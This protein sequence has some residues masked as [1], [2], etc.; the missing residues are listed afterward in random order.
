MSVP[1]P[2]FVE[3]N[4]RVVSAS[5]AQISVFDR[6]LLY[7]DGLFETV[8]AYHGK[9]F[10]LDEH[11]ARLKVSA[12]FLGIVLPRK[13]WQRD[14]LAL[15][16]R[17][18]LQKTDA[19]VRITVTRGV[20]ALGLAPPTRTH[21]TIIIGTGPLDPAITTAQRRGVRVTFLPFARNG[22]LAEHKVLNYLP[23]VLGKVIAVR[24]RAFEGLFVNAEGEV[25]EGTTSNLFI[26]YRGQ[27]CT[28]PIAGILP[29][30]TR[31][32][33]IEAAV[34]DGV[35]VTER[36]VTTSDMLAADEAF[37]TSSLIEVV[38]ITGVD[39]QATGDG[40]VGPCTQRIQRLCRK[41]IDHALA[42]RVSR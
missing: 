16:A 9:P 42:R 39:A 8:R 2:T 3:L 13:A 11:L 24:H 29:G 7:G 30:L 36:A 17:N 6:G 14:I 22:F 38:P 28:P 34:A 25:T 27:L 32:L 5:R 26:W 15:L 10:A 18:R 33:V 19:W 1:A 37:L 31:R 40:Q 23:G 35:R 21:P 20:A 12:R 4:G 41:I